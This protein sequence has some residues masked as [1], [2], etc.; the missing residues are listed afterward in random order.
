MKKTFFAICAVLP[1]GVIL[2]AAMALF[3]GCSHFQAQSQGFKIEG[4]TGSP[5]TIML[6]DAE[7]YATKKCADQPEKCYMGMWGL[8]FMDTTTGVTWAGIQSI[9]SYENA[10]Q[11][12]VEKKKKKIEIKIE[13]DSFKNIQPPEEREQP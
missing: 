13:K 11:P 4:I 9:R 10:N 1:G 12:P 7:A 2:L 8:N 3:V 5:E 6:A